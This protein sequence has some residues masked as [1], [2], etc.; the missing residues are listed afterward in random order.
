MTQRKRFIMGVLSVAICILTATISTTLAQRKHG[1]RSV[2]FRN[3]SYHCQFKSS[4]NIWGMK[5]DP[6]TIVLRRGRNMV[7][8]EHSEGEYGSAVDSIKYLD[9]DGDGKEEAFVVVS[10][11]QEAAGAYWEADYFVFAYRDG[12]SL[13]VFHEYRYKPSGVQVM[14]KSI[15]I[16][17]YLWREDDAHCCPSSIETSVYGWRGAGLVRIS[18]RLKPMPKN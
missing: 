17:A 9:F 11:T 7:K 6:K 2:D 5:V 8:G 12:V 18:R 10:T 15:V 14:G 16:T 3:F 4:S 1:V 13:P